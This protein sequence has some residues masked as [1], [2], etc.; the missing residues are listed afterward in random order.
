MYNFCPFISV[1]Y[2]LNYS[3]NHSFKSSIGLFIITIIFSLF[4]YHYCFSI[5]VNMYRISI[6]F[7]YCTQYHYTTYS[8][9]SASPGKRDSEMRPISLY[10]LVNV[11]RKIT[12][13]T[14]QPRSPCGLLSISTPN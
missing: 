4:F 8:F 1:T 10:S 2:S 11:D 7:S 14:R 5:H 13:G 3:I 6:L 9:P 12:H